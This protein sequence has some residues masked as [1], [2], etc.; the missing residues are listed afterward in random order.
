MPFGYHLQGPRVAHAHKRHTIIPGMLYV[1]F[2]HFRP[3][4]QVQL[5]RHVRVN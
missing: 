5:G 3:R 2:I 4:F 1:T